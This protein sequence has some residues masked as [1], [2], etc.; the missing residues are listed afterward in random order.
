LPNSDGKISS[1]NRITVYG[2]KV[3]GVQKRSAPTTIVLPR[4]QSLR[5]AGFLS[6]RVEVAALVFT[7]GC[8]KK[9]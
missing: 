2:T 7:V 6:P 1:D 3:L 9:F 8:W 4:W 5:S